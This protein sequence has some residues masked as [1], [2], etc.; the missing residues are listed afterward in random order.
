MNIFVTFAIFIWDPNPAL[1]DVALPILN[2]PILWYGFLF[3]VAFFLSTFIFM[4][5]L[6]RMYRARGT[7]EDPVQARRV[8]D[9][10]LPYML[11]G[12]IIGGRILDVLCYQ[13]GAYVW[14]HPL[15]ILE[16]WNG[17]LASHGAAVGMLLSL[18]LF[19]AR[20]GKKYSLDLLSCLDLLAIPV[21]L[22][23]VFIRIGNFINQEIVGTLTALPWGVRF[24]HAADGSSADARHPVQLYEALFYFFLFFFLWRAFWRR[25]ALQPSGQIVGWFLVCSFS[26]R[27]LLEYAKVEQSA[28]W[29]IGLFTMGQMLSVPFI[30]AGVWLLHRLQ[31]SS[32]MVPSSGKK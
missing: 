6:R 18:W 17:G 11:L 13:D 15:S 8:T 21:S 5:L 3:A 25:S 26:A 9:A 2:R 29:S 20:N 24:L 4:L 32:A 28:W 27:F 30:C 31:S 22:A 1:F 16:V 14:A 10:L 19:V 23:A 12:A 7:C